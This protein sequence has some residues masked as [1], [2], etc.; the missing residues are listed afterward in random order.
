MA[1]PSSL[2]ENY[3]TVTCGQVLLAV[4]GHDF[5]PAGDEPRLRRTPAADTPDCAGR[6]DG[7]LY[8]RGNV[9]WTASITRVRCF[10]DFAYP[11]T[12]GTITAATPEDYAR[13]WLRRH[14]TALPAGTAGLA[15][16]GGRSW[17]KAVIE[18]DGTT[19]AGWAIVTYNIQMTDAE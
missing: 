4:D 18:A 10:L 2:L 15:W 5:L 6:E 19:D 17:G 16:T 12:D 11:V 14:L 7:E 8:G 3:D 1:I 9:R 13:K